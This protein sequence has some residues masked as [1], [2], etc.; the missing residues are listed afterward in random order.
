MIRMSSDFL[1]QA[2]EL[3]GISKT[4]GISRGEWGKGK[5]TL[6]VTVDNFH[7]NKGGVAHGGL[8]T[9]MLD[10]SLGGALV[11]TLK[12]DEWCATTQLVTSFIDAARIGDVLTSS[13]RIVRRGRN[14]AHL[15]GEIKT[16]SGRLIASAKGTWAIWESRPKNLGLRRAEALFDIF[17]ERLGSSLTGRGI[18]IFQ[19]NMETKSIMDVESI[20]RLTDDLPVSASF[21]AIKL[22]ENVSNLKGES[23]HS[24]ECELRRGSDGQL[25]ILF[26]KGDK[27]VRK[28]VEE[29]AESIRI[30][31]T[32]QSPESWRYFLEDGKLKMHL[33]LEPEKL[34][35]DYNY[36]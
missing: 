30:T 33:W 1:S 18:W 31:S 9:M 25:Y 29:G 26:T 16:Q 27:T 5:C 20:E 12:K 21:E 28:H 7:T 32:N 8:Y 23:L 15:E 10:S 3:S 13:G 19:D 6:H 22:Q 2:P 34:S 4:L 17:A 11:S 14:V 36:D 35:I 24:D